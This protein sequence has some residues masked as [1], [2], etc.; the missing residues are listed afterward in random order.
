MILAKAPLRVSF[1]GGGSDLEKHYLKYG[2]NV[3]STAINKYV[4]VAVNKTPQKH[5]K[6]SY[7]KQELVTDVN[8]IQNEIVKNTLKYFNINSG[9]DISS[10]A[11]IPT[12]GTGLAGSSAFTCAL[13]RA[14]GGL[15]GY[16]FNEYDVAELAC[17]IEIDLCGWNIGK[18]DQYASSFG[19]MNHIEFKPSGDINITRLNPNHIDTYM[20]LIPTNIQ[21]HASDILDAVDFNKKNI[22]IRNLSELAKTYSKSPV[23]FNSM[24]ES[25]RDAWDLKKQM[26]SGIS[27]PEIDDIIS[28]CES[29]GGYA[30]KVLGAGGGGYVL[31]LTD[32]RNGVKKEF[33][34]RVCLDVGISYHGAKIVYKD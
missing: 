8:D 20:I 2:G 7:S 24:C 33:Y 28:R 12:V 34:D 31:V 15:Y 18:Q 10:F 27:T 23:K 17:H 26:D 1:L 14:I 22:I 25:L 13:I 29:V 30:G 4:Y 32:N 16:N 21:R 9:I 19:G 3:I 5:I 6:L 11:D